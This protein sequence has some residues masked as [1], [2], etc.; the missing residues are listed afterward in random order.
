MAFTEFVPP[1]RSMIVYQQTLVANSSLGWTVWKPG[2][3]VLNKDMIE[4]M[5]FEAKGTKLFY[6]EEMFQ[7]FYSLS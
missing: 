6:F 7:Y 4:L 1:G 3:P 2:S 5:L